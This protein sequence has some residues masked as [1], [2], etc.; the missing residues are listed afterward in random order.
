MALAIEDV[1]SMVCLQLGIRK[2]SAGDRFFEDL[3]AESA[4]VV[5]LAAAA[6][7][8]YDIGFDEEEIAEVR[9]VQQLY[10]LINKLL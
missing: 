10:D 9:T 6:E 8:K 2:V 7:D 1:Q 3:G 5:N 4:D